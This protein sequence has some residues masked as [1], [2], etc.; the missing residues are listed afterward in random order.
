MSFNHLGLFGYLPLFKGVRFFMSESDLLKSYLREYLAKKV[1]GMLNFL[2]ML[3]ILVHRNDCISLLFKAPSRLYLLI[4]NHYRGDVVTAD[5]VFTLLFLN[6]LVS[7]L[8]LKD[9]Q[10]IQ[11]LLECVKTGK[12]EDF[13][14]IIRKYTIKGISA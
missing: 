2:N 7:Y 1:P 5:Y 14:E 12:D 13:I 10:L 9:S 6:P 4:L 3:C 8:N 11:Q